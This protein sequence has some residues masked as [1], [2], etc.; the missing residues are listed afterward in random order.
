MKMDLR[1]FARFAF[2]LVIMAFTGCLV[3]LNSREEMVNTSDFENDDLSLP[4]NSQSY[5][6]HAPNSIQNNGDF[7]SYNFSDVCYTGNDSITFRKQ[8]YIYKPKT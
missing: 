5:V 3:F 8:D 2:L 7:G 1:N 6:V 4:S